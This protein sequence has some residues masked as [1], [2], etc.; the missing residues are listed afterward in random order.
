[1]WIASSK[2]QESGGAKTSVDGYYGGRYEKVVDPKMVIGHQV[3]ISG[4]SYNKSE[5]HS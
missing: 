5:L 3:Q 1:M 2:K 4:N